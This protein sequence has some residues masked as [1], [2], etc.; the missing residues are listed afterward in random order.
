M[1]PLVK[2]CDMIQIRMTVVKGVY[3]LSA[4]PIPVPRELL[5]ITQSLPMTVVT[6]TL[7][8]VT[9][10]IRLYSLTGMVH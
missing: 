8:T 4:V 9:L 2:T 1:V 7:M 3:L 10:L 5:R 6:A